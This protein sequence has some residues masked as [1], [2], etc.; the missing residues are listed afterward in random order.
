[1]KKMK[2][3]LAIVAVLVLAIIPMAFADTVDFTGWSGQ[4][5]NFTY[6]SKTGSN[7][8]EIYIKWND[9]PTWAY[10][11][12]LD[13]TLSDSSA[14]AYYGGV[15]API[16]AMD[17]KEAAWLIAK[18]WTPALSFLERSALQAAIWEVRY[19]DLFTIGVN[20]P[21]FKNYYDSYMQSLSLPGFDAFTPTNYVYLDLGEQVTGAADT[22]QDLITRVP[23][24]GTLLLL[25][26]GLV[27]LAG[28][29]KKFF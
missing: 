18:N 6:S 1:M 7:A 2:T 15:D 14:I 26:L 4:Y 3:K 16:D 17:F 9:V 20:G 11:I 25:G 10:C 21:D 19:D 24:P 27:G 29:R 5:I 13:N 28:L 23:E 12:D 22:V 8:G